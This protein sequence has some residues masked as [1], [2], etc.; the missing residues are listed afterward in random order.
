MIKTYT[1]LYTEAVTPLTQSYL[2]IASGDLFASFQ[3]YTQ[4]FIKELALK[5]KEKDQRGKR[6]HDPRLM[7]GLFEA[8]KQA[9][10]EK[11]TKLLAKRKTALK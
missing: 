6:K 5:Q 4:P 8:R 10:K 2:I 7:A 9:K 1:E 11:T 3:H